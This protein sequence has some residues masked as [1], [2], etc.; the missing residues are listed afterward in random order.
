MTEFSDLLGAI[1]RE[2]DAF[3]ITVSDDWLQGRTLYGGLGGA[4]CLE[5]ALRFV[6]DLPLLRSAQLSFIG[7]ATG[8]LTLRP[9][10]LRQGK[11][12]TYVGVDLFGE[13]GLA[14]RAIFCFGAARRSAIQHAAARAPDV[15]PP[16]ECPNFFRSAPKT[17]SFVS[18]FDGRLA[19]GNMPL[20]GGDPTMTLWLRHRDPVPASSIVPLVALA[21]APPPAAIILFKEFGIISTMTWTLDVLADDLNTDDG[22]WLL[23]TSADHAAQGYS[24]QTMHIW[25][26]RGAPIIAARQNIAVFA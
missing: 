8:R 17:L 11:S 4:L 23:R 21:D 13:A 5:S 16:D 14:T 24:G 20:S 15:K 25:N 10:I 3:T 7:P 26:A 6:P 2:D 9:S 12:T 22:W 18:H 1:V 19:A